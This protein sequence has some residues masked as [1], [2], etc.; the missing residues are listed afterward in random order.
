[1]SLTEQIIY[2]SADVDALIRSWQGALVE[3]GEETAYDTPDVK[4]A[5]KA[6]EIHLSVYQN[7]RKLHGLEALSA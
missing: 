6:T 5:R 1:M 7:I 3:L 4:A 2:K